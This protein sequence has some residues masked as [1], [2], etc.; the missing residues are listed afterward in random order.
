MLRLY[1][2]AGFELWQKFANNAVVCFEGL[3]IVFAKEGVDGP[4]EI[5]RIVDHLP[6]GIAE[7]G[8]ARLDHVYHEVIKRCVG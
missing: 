3:G 5:E 2:H 7:V 6:T 8:D 4:E 1:K